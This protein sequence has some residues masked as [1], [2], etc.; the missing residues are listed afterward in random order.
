MLAA[1]NVRKRATDSATSA[2]GATGRR[3]S[4][5]L[6]YI[7]ESG[8]EWNDGDDPGTAAPA[9]HPELRKARAWNVLRRLPTGLFMPFSCLCPGLIR[10][11]PD[12]KGS[13]RARKGRKYVLQQS[14]AVDAYVSC[15]ICCGTD[16]ACSEDG[17]KCQ[18]CWR[19]YCR[20][21]KPPG[22]VAHVLSECVRYPA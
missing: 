2:A 4:G 14:E 13:R 15:G 12:S 8:L 6:M 5:I 18:Y 19:E 9:P 7:T 1:G 11:E 22:S 16:F 3:R 17:D 20:C 21:E 10:K